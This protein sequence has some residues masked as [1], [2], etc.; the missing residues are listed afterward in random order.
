MAN[1]T[2]L[3]VDDEPM[4]RTLLHRAIATAEIDVVE[5]DS[6]ETAL[7]MVAPPAGFALVVTDILLG[8]MDGVE[9]AQKLS[10]TGRGYRFLFI[11]GYAEDQLIRNC[12]DQFQCAL[13]LEKPFAISD[14]I[15]AVHY[16]LD[17]PSAGGLTANIG[18]G[19]RSYL[20][21]TAHPAIET[22]NPCWESSTVE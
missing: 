8:R 3:V 16:L 11:S 13:F 9:L 20:R 6:A 18:G 5:A 22:Q 1:Y 4:I 21:H 15:H 7:Q 14:L 17:S 2:V 19:R 10:A 12:I